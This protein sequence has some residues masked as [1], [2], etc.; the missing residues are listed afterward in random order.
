MNLYKESSYTFFHWF[1]WTI[2]LTASLFFIVFDVRDD[3]LTIVK[4]HNLSVIPFLTALIVAIIGSIYSIFK[5]VPGGIMMFI[6][7]IGLV[8]S[9]ALQGGLHEF[10]LMVAYALPYI[11]AG[12]FFFFIRNKKVE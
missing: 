12:V 3:V 8:S 6:G 10:G 1:A 9:F 11:I 4:D 5:Q 7:G 2:S